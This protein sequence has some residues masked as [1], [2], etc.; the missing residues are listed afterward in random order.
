MR[1]A[2][3]IVGALFVAA[4]LLMAAGKLHYQHTDRVADFGKLEIDA[5]HEKTAPL[6][7]GYVLLG[8]GAVLLVIGAMTRRP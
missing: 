5:T 4:G 2:L 7:W 3:F 8:G 6:N 1:N